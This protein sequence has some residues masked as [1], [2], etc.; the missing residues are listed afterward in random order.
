MARYEPYISVIL[1][2]TFFG[3]PFPSPEDSLVFLTSMTTAVF[4]YGR[5]YPIT[6]SIC[7]SHRTSTLFCVPVD[8]SYA[9]FLCTSRSICWP[10][11]LIMM[12]LGLPS[13]TH[14]VMTLLIHNL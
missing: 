13:F 1:S 6:I 2:L 8:Y 3:Q 5:R 10:V 9:P 4:S 11:H 7:A 14:A 12:M